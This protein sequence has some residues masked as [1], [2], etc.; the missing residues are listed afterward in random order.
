MNSKIALPESS[1]AKKWRRSLGLRTHALSGLRNSQ[2]VPTLV[3]PR[4]S[5][6][7]PTLSDPRNSRWIPTLSGLRNSRWVPTLL[8]PRN[9]QWLR[10]FTNP[11]QRSRLSMRKS[12]L[13]QAMELFQVT[14][15]DADQRTR[16]LLQI[17]ANQRQKSCHL[18]PFFQR[19]CLHQMSRAH[20][21]LQYFE[22]NSLQ[23]HGSAHPLQSA[24]CS[25]QE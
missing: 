18:A 17:T 1:T 16:F 15:I 3:D 20:C 9:S 10:T 19:V 13:G 2:W 22:S 6:W 24:R 4:N 14:G 11:L 7:I 12:L 25:E 5:Q 8:G 23:D 21:D